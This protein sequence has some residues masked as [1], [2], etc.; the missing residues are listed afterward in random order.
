MPADLAPG[1]VLRVL[2]RASLEFGVVR[3]F[4]PRANDAPVS[5]SKLNSRSGRLCLLYVGLRADGCDGDSV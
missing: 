3:D 2:E 1:G 4:Y 5:G